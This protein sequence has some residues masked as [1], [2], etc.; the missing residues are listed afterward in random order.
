M[1]VLDLLTQSFLHEQ[2]RLVFPD[3]VD[4]LELRFEHR[5]FLLGGN[6][7]FWFND[8]IIL[9]YNLL[10]GL[11]TGSTSLRP[12]FILDVSTD[13]GVDFRIGLESAVSL[14][15]NHLYICQAPGYCLLGDL[16]SLEVYSPTA[17]MLVLSALLDRVI[18]PA[19]MARPCGRLVALVTTSREIQLAPRPVLLIDVFTRRLLSEL[20]PCNDF[21]FLDSQRGVLT[22]GGAVYHVEFFPAD[23]SIKSDLSTQAPTY[24]LDVGLVSTAPNGAVG[25][26]ELKTGLLSVDA[27]NLGLEI[28]RILRMRDMSEAHLINV[29]IVLR[30][31]AQCV[32]HL[33]IFQRKSE[34]HI[35]G[36]P[37]VRS[38]S[39]KSIWAVN[40]QHGAQPE[41]APVQLSALDLPASV[42]RLILGCQKQSS[43]AIPRHRPGMFCSSPS[44][45]S[46][47]LGR[48]PFNNPEPQFD[49]E[50]VVCR[51]GY[52]PVVMGITESE[53]ATLMSNFGEFL[54]CRPA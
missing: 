28:C 1:T 25:A 44:S 36:M 51:I 34:R 50:F 46:T 27:K 12:R 22:L 16:R 2:A 4:G 29:G 40:T 21:H 53:L 33:L 8:T 35:R 14:E 9:I 42:G 15:E 32:D 49:V 7:V 47:Q 37:I 3:L 5:Y 39:F 13:C 48:T 17:Q 10:D 41:S 52:E 19:I 31:T 23:H 20:P 18:H 54:A 6:L 45:N 11:Q 30:P 24:T 38:D 26:T 43:K